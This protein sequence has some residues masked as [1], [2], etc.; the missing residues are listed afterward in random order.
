MKRSLSVSRG[1]V[2]SSR[3]RSSGVA[4]AA[5]VLT[6]AACGG[7]G[8]GASATTPAS[9]G[10]G[11]F[12]SG[13]P[14]SPAEACLAIATAKR[15]KKPDEPAQIT[16]KHVLVKY[17]GSKRAADTVTRTREE[18]CLRAQEARGKLEAGASFV[19]V[20]KEYS[21][22]KG[23]ASREGT[24]GPVGRSDI[25]AP[26]ADAAF[27]LAPGEVSHVVETDFGFH[28]IQRL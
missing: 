12:P 26:F 17:K 5:V 24:V 14:G 21:E 25:A 11:L 19:D 16:V 18:A 6:L 27:E 23:A 13:G 10:A 28:I 3:P 9:P 2:G 8:G 20:V 15:T 1:L 7:G 22:E 4:A